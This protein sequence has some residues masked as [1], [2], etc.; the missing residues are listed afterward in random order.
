MRIFTIGLLAVALALPACQRSS[1]TSAAPESL[2][3]ERESYEDAIAGRLKEFELRFDGLEAR[4]KG[5]PKADQEHLKVD[6][7]ELRDR[8]DDLELKFK[9]LGKVSD[10]SWRELRD[11]FDRSL[12]QLEMAYNVVAANNHG[13][14]A[15]LEFDR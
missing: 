11:S 7:A 10:E 13:T 9:D 12:D 8:K 3:A 14:H 1:R 15:P 6:I 5:L 4:M 2:A